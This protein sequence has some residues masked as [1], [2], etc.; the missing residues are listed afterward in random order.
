[1]NKI[2]KYFWEVRKILNEGEILR[3]KPTMRCNIVCPYCTVNMQRGGKRP[4][5]YEER[6]AAL[7]ISLIAE[8]KP[9]LVVFSGGEPGMYPGLSEVVNYAVRFGCQ[10]QIITNLLVMKEF[11][12]I[13]RSW[14]VVFL[15]TYHPVAPLDLYLSNYNRLSKHFW[16]TVREIRPFEDLHPKYIPWAK[17]K[18]MLSEE[19][20]IP[21]WIYA[22][23]GSLH[24]SCIDLDKGGK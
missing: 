11:E 5:I 12:K 3:I 21:M 23:D 20:K 22:P 19:P 13:N 6:E 2:R 15:A 16:V 14:R 4:P 17:T 9:K 24:K 7:W 18:V 8:K 1:M 10:V